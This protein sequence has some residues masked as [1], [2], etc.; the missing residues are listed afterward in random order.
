LHELRHVRAVL[1]DL[2]EERTQPDP[3]TMAWINTYLAASPP[4]WQLHR[5]SA[6]VRMQM[7]GDADWT[8]VIAAVLASY[9][10]L[11]EDRVIDRVRRCANPQLHLAVLRRVPQR[12]TVL[13]RSASLRESPQRQSPPASGRASSQIQLV[14]ERPV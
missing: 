13:V 5:A 10:Q 14:A 8:A 11:L 1:R 12:L 2:L 3:R 6:R 9:G 7:S 4:V